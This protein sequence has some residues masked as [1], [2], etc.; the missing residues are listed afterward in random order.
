MSPL[1]R[2]SGVRESSSIANTTPASGALNAAAM[3]AAPPAMSK[4]CALTTDRPGNQRR[5]LCMTPA[6]ICTDGPSRPNDSPASRP[7]AVSTALAPVNRIET[8]RLR[9]LSSTEV[10]RAAITCG[11]PEPAAPGA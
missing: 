8:K 5:A 11:M 3:P 1:L 6:A 2:C 7:H 9:L 4:L 10:S